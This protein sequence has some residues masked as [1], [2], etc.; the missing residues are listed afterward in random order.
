MLSLTVARLLFMFLFDINYELYGGNCVTHSLPYL[1]FLFFI[2][3]ITMFL[4][5]MSCSP[6][7]EIQAF[8]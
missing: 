7:A 2:L 6:V 4:I 5:F 1:L 8:I 3:Q